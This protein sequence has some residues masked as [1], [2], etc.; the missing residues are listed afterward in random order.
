MQHTAHANDEREYVRACANY[1]IQKARDL[2]YSRINYTHNCP[3]LR[4]SCAHNTF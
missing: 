3:A 2:N 4:I 1:T